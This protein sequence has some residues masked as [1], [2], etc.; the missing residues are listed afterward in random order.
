MKRAERALESYLVVAAQGGD[1]RAM[2]Q[3]VTLRGPRL[4]AHATRLLG[5]REGARDVV[6]DA[7]AEIVRGLG[8]LRDAAA[9]LPW[10]LRIVSRRVARVIK[11]RQRDRRLAGGYAAEVEVSVPEAGPAA[12]DAGVVRRAI[13]S[14]PP[15]QAATVALFYL[16]NM[17]VGDVAMAMDVP[18]GTVKTR[19]MH[20]RGKLRRLLEGE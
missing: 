9:F 17:S 18:A 19:L 12:V 5:E 15:D 2:A 20:A 6:Q 3:L 4:L 1:R 8:G 10:A 13:A 14:L 16:E 11:G 7:W